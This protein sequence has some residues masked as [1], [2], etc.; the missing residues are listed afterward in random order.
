VSPRRF[1]MGAVASDTHSIRDTRADRLV[2]ESSSEEFDRI[3]FAL[4]VLRLL[5]P[6]RMTIAV[7]ECRREMRVERGR[8]LE[9][10]RSATWGL[11]GVSRRASR[12]HIVLA[13][14]EL[15]GSP[16]PAFLVDLLSAA[17]PSLPSLE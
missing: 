5:A 2:T 13:A 15:A 6:P 9:R 14:A 12:Q 1:T 3:Q 10:G 11:L 7:Y 8:D 16:Q 17:A 4:K